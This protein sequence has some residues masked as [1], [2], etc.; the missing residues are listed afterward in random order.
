LD[1]RAHLRALPKPGSVVFVG[2]HPVYSVK[3]AVS[4]EPSWS[5]PR[6]VSRLPE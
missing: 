4:L 5:A 1:H 6:N 2:R 3:I